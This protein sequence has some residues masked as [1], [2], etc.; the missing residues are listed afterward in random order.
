MSTCTVTVVSNTPPTASDFTQTVYRATLSQFSLKVSDS[1]TWTHLL[2][3]SV[4]DPPAHGTVTYRDPDSFPTNSYS[5][6]FVGE[7][8]YT[9]GDSFTYRATDGVLTSDVA[10]CTLKA[11][12]DLLLCS[13]G[14]VKT[15]R[16]RLLAVF[17]LAEVLHV[18]YILFVTVKGMFGTFDWRGRRSSAV[19]AGCGEQQ[20]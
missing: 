7:S 16:L 18:P 2:E 13:Y 12:G 8:G 4:V 9:G 17:P 3:C 15:G 10:T 5:L 11:A 19:S 1:E 14:A 6:F 20:V